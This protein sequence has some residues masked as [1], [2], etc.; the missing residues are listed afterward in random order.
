MKYIN[1]VLVLSGF[2]WFFSIILLNYKFFPKKRQFGRI[3]NI[4][5]I[6]DYRDVIQSEPNAQKKRQLK[7]VLAFA[8]LTTINWFLQFVIFLF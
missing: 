8:V 2:L 1:I 3:M 4:R 6:S 7:L 5:A